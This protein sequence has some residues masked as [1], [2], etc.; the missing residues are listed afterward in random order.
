MFG[1]IL[2]SQKQSFLHDIV[3]SFSA[4]GEPLQVSNISHAVWFV[5]SKH[6]RTKTNP[7]RKIA[8]EGSETAK[9]R[10]ILRD[11]VVQIFAFLQSPEGKQFYK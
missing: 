9:D 4:L 5:N 7:F 1:P 11:K 10:I 3:T 2:L 8:L 6:H